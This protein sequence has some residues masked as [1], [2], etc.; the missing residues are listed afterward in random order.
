MKYSNVRRES[1]LI[2]GVH[3]QSVVFLGLELLE[4]SLKGGLWL[5]PR[6][7]SSVTELALSGSHPDRFVVRIGQVQAARK[8]ASCGF[9]LESP[10]GRPKPMVRG[11]L[12]FTPVP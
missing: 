1:K 10:A 8:M 3:G 11:T 2:Q 7:Y 6:G 9:Q 4:E 12:E 5:G